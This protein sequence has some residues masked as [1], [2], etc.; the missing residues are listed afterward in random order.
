[1]RF[2]WKLAAIL[3][4]VLLLTG[5]VRDPQP[6][7]PQET[8]DPEQYLSV[9]S[10]AISKIEKA[11]DRILSVTGSQSR[12]VGS[13]NFTSSFSQRIACQ[14]LT[15]KPKIYQQEGAAYGSYK[16]QS[17]RIFRN[18][19]AYYSVSDRTFRSSMTPEAFLETLTPPVLLDP[20]LYADVTAE[21]QGENVRLFFHNAAALE[22]WVVPGQRI[23]PESASAEALLRPDGSLDKTVYRAVFQNGAAKITLEVT[24]QVTLPAELDLSGQMSSI[25]TDCVELP[26]LRIPELLMQ[27]AA[28]LYAA[29]SIC[30]STEE[31]ID[32]AAIKTRRVQKIDLL[33]QGAGQLLDADIQ[34]TVE[35]SDY[36]GNLTQSVTKETYSDGVFITV[37]DGGSPVTSDSLSPENMQTHCEDLLLMSMFAISHLEDADIDYD[38][39]LCHIRFI[40]TEAMTQALCQNIYTLLGVDLDALSSEHSGDPVCGY[41]TIDLL[42]GVPA[43]AGMTLQKTHTVNGTGQLLSYQLDQSYTFE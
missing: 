2:A 23:Q 9:L 6:Q 7:Q 41:L 14:D 35:L 21:Y 11:D 42:T 1:M 5:C 27:A 20:Q 16:I 3:I 32:S 28:D 33:R 13:Q 22:S 34:Y 38:E 24:C 29:E 30:S 43:A 12:Q 26:D 19:S 8:A 4:W 10:Q 31:V 39:G 17:I 40:G 37:T 15:D 18:R 36:T 25:P